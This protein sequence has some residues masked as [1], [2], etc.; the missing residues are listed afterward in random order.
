MKNAK[1][2]HQLA[3]V[4][5]DIGNSSTKIAVQYLD[6]DGDDRRWFSQVTLR[7]DDRI[8]LEL[9]AAPAFWSVC[10]VNHDRFDRLRQWISEHRPQDQ[11]HVISESDVA[12]GSAVIS[13]QYVGRD[14][15]V[16]AAMAVQLSDHQGPIVVIDAGT[17][18]TIDLVDSNCIFQG[19]VIFL[20]GSSSLRYLSAAAPALPDLSN[21]SFAQ[22]SEFNNSDIIGKDTRS[23]ILSGVYC[24]QII[25]ISEIAKKLG[26]STLEPYCVFATGGGILAIEKY[27][28]Q[29]WHF[30]PDLVLRGAKTIGRRLLSERLA[31]P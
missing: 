17:A 3:L 29:N 5:V 22:G 14:Q 25:A 1:T 26:E 30:V 20:G 21:C 15:L 11:V 12:I 4:A 19:G 27:L 6:N 10:S 28:P 7:G 9:T 2:T 18:V 23:A 31:N 13:R 24:S 8:H 16:A